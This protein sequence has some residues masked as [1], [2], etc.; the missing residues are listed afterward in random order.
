MIILD[1]R[2]DRVDVPIAPAGHDHEEVG[3]VDLAADIEDLDPDRL[4]VHAGRRELEG[5]LARGLGRFGRG[6]GR[7]AP[8][9]ARPPRG[10]ERRLLDGGTV[11]LEP[12]RA[13]SARFVGGAGARLRASRTFVPRRGR[14]RRG[15]RGSVGASG[16]RLAGPAAG[17]SP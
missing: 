14:V 3:V 1:A 2:R 12:G 11:G 5:E 13:R 7:D 8:S 17:R 9:R 16:A 6:V 15:I 4:L 10:A